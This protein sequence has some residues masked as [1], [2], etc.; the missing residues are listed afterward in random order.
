MKLSDIKKELFKRC[1]Y[2]SAG[3]LAESTGQTEPFTNTFINSTKEANKK[4]DVIFEAMTE[5]LD[6]TVEEL[7][8]AIDAY[9]LSRNYVV[10]REQFL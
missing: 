6:M 7:M 5:E 2:S 8:I 9:L 10:T 3:K 4:E 1:K